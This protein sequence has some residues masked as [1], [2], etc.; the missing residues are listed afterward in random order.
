MNSHLIKFKLR[1]E[2]KVKL[3]LENALEGR[4]TTIYFYFYFYFLFC[5]VLFCFG[6]AFQSLEA[7]FCTRV[8]CWLFNLLLAFYSFINYFFNHVAGY[9]HDGNYS[10]SI[11]HKGEI[12]ILKTCGFLFRFVE[13]H[14]HGPFFKM[15]NYNA[16]QLL[17]R[18]FQ[19]LHMMIPC[20]NENINVFGK[21]P[22]ILFSQCEGD[23]RRRDM[24]WEIIV[25][26]KEEEMDHEK[27]MCLFF[28]QN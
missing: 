18:N 17:G 24:Q 9:S 22:L 13:I 25:K 12:Q 15:S 5:F 3:K 20:N 26:I 8:V 14:I 7:F 10:Q 1:S 16:F 2:L 4:V 23:Q 28:G 6:E 21:K 19:P 27:I 11:N